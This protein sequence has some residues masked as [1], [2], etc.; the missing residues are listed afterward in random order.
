VNQGPVFCFEEVDGY[1]AQTD[2]RLCPA[3]KRQLIELRPSTHRKLSLGKRTLALLFQAVFLP[4]IW[5]YKG[6]L[7]WWLDAILASRSQ[8]ALKV[9]V[10]SDLAFLFDNYGATVVPNGQQYGNGSVVT[11][12]TDKL[13]FEAS[14]HHG[15]YSLRIAP[16]QAPLDWEDI[17]VVLTAM[18]VKTPI[19]SGTDISPTHSWTDLAGLGRVLESQILLIEESLSQGHYEETIRTMEKLEEIGRR[20]FVERWKKSAKFYHEHPE[21]DPWNKKEEI[22]TLGVKNYPEI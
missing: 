16:P 9:K 11:L 5:I 2:R 18:N 4:I 15:E 21:A 13:R 20:R 8:E 22:Q 19:N 10:R 6:L 7:G 1:H 14:W 3:Q 17:A 12:E